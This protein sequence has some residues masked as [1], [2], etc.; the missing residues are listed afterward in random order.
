[1]PVLRDLG[2]AS[3]G[4]AVALPAEQPPAV[5]FLRV[6]RTE[7]VSLILDDLLIHAHYGTF[8]RRD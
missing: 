5:R 2:M 6:A 1:M 8:F 7:E 3:C 4:R